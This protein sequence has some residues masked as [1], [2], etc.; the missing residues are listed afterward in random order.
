ME[1]MISILLPHL[2]IIVAVV[3]AVATVVTAKIAKQKRKDDL[4]KIRWECYQEIIKYIANT[5]EQNCIC[6]YEKIIDHRE[7]PLKKQKFLRDKTPNYPKEL[8]L[9]QY[10]LISKI[11]NLFDAEI[12]NLIQEFMFDFSFKLIA[13]SIFEKH[14]GEPQN[15]NER[16]S[17]SWLPSQEFE[18]LFD[19]YLKLK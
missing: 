6:F 19:E 16:W 2:T 1:C 11:K 12:A 7:F 5:Y 10:Y 9:E 8:T 4:F 14:I 17:Y 13:K 3:T 18:Q 15:I